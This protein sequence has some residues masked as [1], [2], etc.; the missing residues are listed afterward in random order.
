MVV[1]LKLPWQSSLSLAYMSVVV[2][3]SKAIQSAHA[4]KAKEHC[5]S[6]ILRYRIGWLCVHCLS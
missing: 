2:A 3:R 5:T 1:V 6:S 4:L